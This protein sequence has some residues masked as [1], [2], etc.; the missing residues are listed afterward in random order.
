MV[1]RENIPHIYKPKEG[2]NTKIDEDNLEMAK[3]AVVSGMSNRKAEKS[4]E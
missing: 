4:L 1:I 3:R 2:A